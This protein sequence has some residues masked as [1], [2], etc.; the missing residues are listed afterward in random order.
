MGSQ[1]TSISVVYTPEVLASKSQ[2]SAWCRFCPPVILQSVTR[3]YGS[4]SVGSPTLDPAFARGCTNPVGPF[5]DVPRE[6]RE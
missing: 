4:Y 5:S 1:G 2:I 3:T 6:T